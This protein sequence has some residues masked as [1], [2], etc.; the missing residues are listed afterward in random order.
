MVMRPLSR[1]IAG[2]PRPYLAN[3]SKRLIFPALART[4]FSQTILSVH[5]LHAPKA[6]R[7]AHGGLVFC[8]RVFAGRRRPRIETAYV[9]VSRP[10]GVQ[11]VPR[12]GLEPPRLAALVP[13]T[14]ASTNSATWA[15]S[16][17]GIGDRYGAVTALSIERVKAL[18]T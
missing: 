14:S 7:L 9:F 8:V 16:G 1:A 17:F 4:F 6:V 15:V 11:V 5:R 18:Y 12:R 2:I 10:A 13:E 3:R